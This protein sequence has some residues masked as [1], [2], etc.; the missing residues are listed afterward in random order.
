MWQSIPVPKSLQRV[1]LI[2][3]AEL[4]L[5]YAK[6]P[7]AYFILLL[8]AVF[9]FV[10][11]YIV[12]VGIQDEMLQF[13]MDEEG[14]LSELWE[15]VMLL[16]SFAL[17]TVSSVQKARRAYLVPA[18]VLLYMALDGRMRIHESVGWSLWPENGH[19]GEFLYMSAMGAAFLLA[20]IWAIRR[21]SAV[22]K[23]ELTCYAVLL[24][25]FGLF[26]T[27]LDLLHIFLSKLIARSDN[28]V[29]WVEDGGELLIISLMLIL[30]LGVFRRLGIP[31]KAA[32]GT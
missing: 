30:S 15:F 18:L 32:P 8:W 13:R 22:Q 5:G 3:C 6:K 12:L 7:G 20:L 29:A 14:S 2:S 23:S 4:L 26:G 24:V 19:F 21:S 17:L 31:E 27:A 1:G 9:V 16:A 25:L 11:A 28:L 10:H